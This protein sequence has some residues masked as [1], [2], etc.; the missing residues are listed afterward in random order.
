MHLKSIPLLLTSKKAA[1]LVLLTTSCL[2]LLTTEI[3]VPSAAFLPSASV[4]SLSSPYF[5][6]TSFVV[7]DKKDSAVTK[8]QLKESSNSNRNSKKGYQFGD[9]TKSLIKQIT[10]KDT[11]EF[12]DLSKHFDSTIKNR[13]AQLSDKNEYEFGDLTKYLIQDFTNSSDNSFAGTGETYSYKFG[14]I[15]KEIIN[16]VKSREYTLDDLAIL[17]KALVSFGVG[18]SPVAS[19][20]PVKLLI[21]LLNYSIAGDLSTKVISSIS[22]ELDKR[23]KK[24][25]TGDESYQ[26]GDY[27]K[28][29]ILKYIGRDEYTFGDITKTVVESMEKYEAQQKEIAALNQK[30]KD[31]EQIIKKRTFLTSDNDFDKVSKDL[32]AWDE[33]YLKDLN[34]EESK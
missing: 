14:D 18:L 21:D 1:T 10:K 12:G 23:M 11:Y 32:E 2:V 27:S 8:T 7:V 20:L 3:V 13:I 4:Q 24:A 34:Q 19:F 28:K 30:V 26:I 16:R 5:R 15:T 9:I 17:I 33:K 6:S 22:L 25:I 29:A 31:E